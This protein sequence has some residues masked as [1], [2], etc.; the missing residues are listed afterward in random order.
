ML[1]RYNGYTVLNVT[2]AFDSQHSAKRP[3]PL[4][5]VPLVTALSYRYFTKFAIISDS[6]PNL[7]LSLTVINIGCVRMNI[8]KAI[9]YR[10]AH[11][12]QSE[13]QR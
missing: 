6:I 8:S 9:R 10:H 7:N 4:Y 1:K 11:S 13:P 5:E 12:A 3:R 2:A